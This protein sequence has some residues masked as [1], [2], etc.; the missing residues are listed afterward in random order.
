MK[1]KYLS[2]V[3]IVVLLA[4]SILLLFPK[5]QQEAESPIDRAISL[6]RAKVVSEVPTE[7]EVAAEAALYEPP[8][9]F[10][11]LQ[12]VNSDI[13]AWL[14]IP[15][16]DI[17]Y[18]ILRHDTDNEFYLSH[19]EN[20]GSSEAGAIYVEDYNSRE[21]DD[22]A[23]AVYGHHLRNGAYF[24]NLQ[25]IYET[26]DGFQD[27]R[28]IWIYLPQRQIHF[29]VFAAVPYNDTHLLYT[30]HFNNPLEYDQFVERI[31]AVRSLNAQI[32]PT[33]APQSQE[34]LVILSTCLKADNR[35]R[36]LVIGAAKEPST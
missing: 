19:A 20:R 6:E 3:L 12:S 25:N 7:P 33:E 24:G 36:Y 5:E 16:T 2:L 22:P 27:H 35:Q 32:D 15:G 18:P 17:S 31:L 23:L 21:L 29:R 8:V 4:A 28:D 34:Q 13:I 26:A 14:D 11:A 1:M 30:Y 10:E 9:D